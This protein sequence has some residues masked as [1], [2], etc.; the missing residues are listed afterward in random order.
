MLLFL[1]TALSTCEEK[2]LSKISNM[3]TIIW[4]VSVSGVILFSLVVL[5]TIWCFRVP[6]D[7]VMEKQN[8]QL[9]TPLE[10]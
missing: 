2:S 6:S 3:A 8:E 1:L 7:D 5:F 4:I 10:K 9:N